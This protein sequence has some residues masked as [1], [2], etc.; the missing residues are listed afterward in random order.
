V[1]TERLES[2]RE[3]GVLAETRGSHGY[4]EYVLTDKGLSLWPVVRDLLSWGDEY[5]S[6]NG[7]RRVFQHAQ[8]AGTIAPDGTCAACGS[9]VPRRTCCCFPAP[10]MTG[11]G[12]TSSARPSPP[13]TACSN[14]FAASDHTGRP[15]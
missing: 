10:A 7:P 9:A 2:L 11:K 15:A 14:P 8:D 12:T 5:Y 4:G 13:R 3:A 1:L 6:A